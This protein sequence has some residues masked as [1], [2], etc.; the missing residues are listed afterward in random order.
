MNTFRLGAAAAVLVCL[1]TGVGGI[2]P[3]AAAPPPVVNDR[4]AVNGRAAVGATAAA[5]ADPAGPGAVAQAAGRSRVS[6]SGTGARPAVGDVADL[7]DHVPWVWPVDGPRIVAGYV[8]PA[9]DYGPGHR[10]IDAAPARPGDVRAP[11]S[12]V[13]AFAGTVVDRPLVTIDHGDGLVTT[14]EPVDPTVAVGTTV[15]RG[16]VV[17]ALAV[18]GHT[19]PGALHFGVRLHGA[20][21]NPL[22][23]LGGVPRAVLLPCCR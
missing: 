11:A 9:H 16:Q 10:G 18:G 21:I 6:R 7:P 17:G 3:A 15:T 4:A 13:V 23:L 22:L 20:Y 14:L 1:C 19:P 12:G 2:V 8:A 5:M